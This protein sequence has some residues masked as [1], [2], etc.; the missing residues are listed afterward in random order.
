MIHVEGLADFE[1]R[2]ARSLSWQKKDAAAFK[3]AGRHALKIFVKHAKGNIQD[4]S[5]DIEVIRKSGRKTVQ[6]GT[7]RRS[8][9]IWAVKRS[10]NHLSAGP[11]AGFLNRQN[12]AE[13]NDAWFAH[14]VEGG[15]QFGMNLQTR[16]TGVIERSIKA[17]EQSV[18][19]EYAKQL[20]FNFPKYMK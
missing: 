1:R 11:R 7:L 5:R 13:R 16:N 2:I 19:K 4:F 15:N 17:T 6:K 10:G 3:A 12:F 20:R 8:I 14:I 9:G 18:S